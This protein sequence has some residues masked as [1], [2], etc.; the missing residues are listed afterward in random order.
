MNRHSSAEYRDR[1]AR[2]AQR[3]AE[4]L[5]PEFKAKWL[6]LAQ[7][8]ESV[9]NA[10]EASEKRS[11]AAADARIFRLRAVELRAVADTLSAPSA[12]GICA[13]WPT[14]M[15]TWRHSRRGVSPNLRRLSALTWRRNRASAPF[16]VLM[17]RRRARA[18]EAGAGAAAECRV[19]APA[20]SKPARVLRLSATSA[21]RMKRFA[22]KSQP[23]ADRAMGRRRPASYL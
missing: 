13:S 11:G 3:P 8:Y 18:L 21:S 22:E 19:G 23:Q 7:R 15:T 10:L 6:K 2:A 16:L 5:H 20:R 14:A 12:V 17:P 9:A 4:T 1:A